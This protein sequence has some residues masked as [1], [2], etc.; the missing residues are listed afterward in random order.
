MNTLLVPTSRLLETFSTSVTFWA[1]SASAPS[2]R[3]PQHRAAH[4]GM[5]A[6]AERRVQGSLC[7]CIERPVKHF[8]LQWPQSVL[9]PA[10]STIEATTTV[11]GKDQTG[12]AALVRRVNDAGVMGLRGRQGMQSDNVFLAKRNFFTADFIHQR[13]Q[14]PDV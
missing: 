11:C 5:I 14:P 13:R 8:R 6:A 2:G 10:K 3:D 1:F 12:N 4:F 9:R 7:P